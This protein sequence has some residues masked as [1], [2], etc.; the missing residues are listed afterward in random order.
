MR[1]LAAALLA[2]LALPFEALW[3]DF[4][5]ARR[6]L[7][8]V[9]A[10]LL[11]LAAPKWLHA[12]PN[13]ASVL[14][15]ALASVHA[16]RSFG[17]ANPVAGF[18]RALHLLALAVFFE[19]GSRL[20]ARDWL[21][22]ALPAGA[23]VAA[24]GIAQAFGLDW[25][26]GYASIEQPVSTLGNKNFASEF[27]AVCGAAAATLLVQHQAS[28]AALVT[29]VLTAIYLLLNGSRSGLLALPLASAAL[30][31]S[32]DGGP[33]GRL[34]LLIALLA[35][36]GVALLTQL[37]RPQPAAVSAATS[38][39]PAPSTV[40]VRLEIWKGCAAMAAAAPVLGHG[41]AQF[42]VVYPRYRTAREI[43]LST[44][45][46]EFEARPTTAHNDHLD[47]LTET[48]APGLLL[49]WAFF[50][51]AARGHWR[52]PSALA[53]LVAFLVLSLVRAPLGNAPVAAL[54]F[55]HL[56]AL[57]APRQAARL[58]FMPLATVGVGA[59]MLWCGG[60]GVLAAHAS[61]AFM[62]R[63]ARPPVAAAAATA[64]LEAA[65][66]WRDHEPGWHRLLAQESFEIGTPASRE[67][68]LA[69]WRTADMLDPDDVGGLILEA[70]QLQAIGRPTEALRCLKRALDLDPRHPRAVLLAATVLCRE[71]K[72]AECLAMLYRDPHP[73]LRATLAGNLGELAGVA[74]A[75][76]DGPGAELLTIEQSYVAAVDALQRAPLTARRAVE[77]LNELLAAAGARDLRPFA[78]QAVY[79]LALDQRAVADELAAAAAE[80]RLTMTAPHRRLL[81]E[82]ATPLAAIAAWRS[83]L[84][85]SN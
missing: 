78:L 73:R 24:Y 77:R 23:L 19:F 13:R 65:I 37:A 66:A 53:P 1:T 79:A 22:A 44:F 81:G 41:S 26:A 27:A 45:G 75:R 52:R 47:V 38:T 33:R 70:E 58:R 56:G 28:R 80:R 72:V 5:T 43:E 12:A 59:V 74:R 25:P 54:V 11:A 51:V 35:G 42:Q 50:A 17:V 69:A 21:L 18:E 9:V 85:P 57:Q 83:L 76:G 20:P 34:V 10:G 16:L 36:T 32:R 64:E 61:T 8:L 15:L 7:L 55:A 60:G 14:L 6:S 84:E 62:A 71:G 63:L 67:R 48:G 46:Y 49:L 39:A 4:E 31:A 82:L 40:Q 29:L 30:F 3:F 2:V 68:A